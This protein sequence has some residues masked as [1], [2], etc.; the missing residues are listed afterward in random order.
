MKKDNIFA[1]HF[2]KV[3]EEELSNSP[4]QGDDEELQDISPERD[5]FEGTLDDGT[6]PAEYDINPNSF[7]QINKSNIIGAKKWIA[8]L[9]DFADLINSIDNEDSL[10]HFLNRVDRDG[11]AFRGVV[12]SQGKRVTRIAEE[13]AGMAEVLASHVVGSDRKERELLQQFPNLKK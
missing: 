2:L 3:L 13:A 5:A 1:K 8:I 9:N 11:S 10:N 4:L 6:D 7:K 12:R